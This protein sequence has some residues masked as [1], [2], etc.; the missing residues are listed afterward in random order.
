MIV[1]YFTKNYFKWVPIFLL[2][3]K[4]WNGEQEKIVFNC[5]NDVP[6]KDIKYLYSLYSNLIIQVDKFPAKYI[7]NKL[8]ITTK[9][10]NR[11]LQDLYMGKRKDET[12]LAVMMYLA[13]HVRIQKLFN[14]MKSFENESFFIHSDIDMYFRKPILEK[15]KLYDKNYDVGIKF[16]LN[17]KRDC[18]KTPITFLTFNNNKNM[19]S[20]MERWLY[21]INSNDILRD[22]KSVFSDNNKTYYGQWALYKAYMEHKETLNF[23]KIPNS[24]RDTEYRDSSEIWSANK[25]MKAEGR[26]KDKH[27]TYQHIKKEFEKEMK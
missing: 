1:A 24:F 26:G 2:S 19:I 5:Y 6:K 4:K 11:H 17:K 18:Q 9:E 13:D 7:T 12:T 27:L 10:L 21:W 20:F 15:L 23:F 14:V 25:C 22:Y 8:K 3:W 16:Q